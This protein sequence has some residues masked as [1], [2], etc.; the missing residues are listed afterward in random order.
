MLA[1]WALFGE[2][3]RRSFQL[4]RKAK[5]ITLRIPQVKDCKNH[6]DKKKEKGKGT[7]VFICE[8]QSAAGSITSCRDVNNQAVFV[9][10][11]KPL[12]VWDLKRDA[13]YRKSRRFSKLIAVLFFYAEARNGY[14]WQP[15]RQIMRDFGWLRLLPWVSSPCSE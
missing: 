1:R 13:M 2:C 3:R 14:A 12:N 8:G 7:M 9:L 10:K 6:F 15:D 11:G 4:Y 5:A